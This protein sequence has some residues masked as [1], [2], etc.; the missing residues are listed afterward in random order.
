M[1]RVIAFAVLLALALSIG[2]VAFAQQNNEP[3]T[4]HTHEYVITSVSGGEIAYTCTS[5]GE[6]YSEYF[7]DYLNG[8]GEIYDVNY[9]GIIN[10][11]D[12]AYLAQNKKG[13]K[14]VGSDDDWE[15]SLDL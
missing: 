3:Q 4:S 14:P 15:A 8:D 13:W 5:C 10:G 7:A 1:K 9:D 6:S 2:L 12:Y 11:K